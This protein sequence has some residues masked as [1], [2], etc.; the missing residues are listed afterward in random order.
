MIDAV[1]SP[2]VLRDPVHN[3]IPLDG[4]DGA[5]VL[6]LIDTP[7]FQRLRRIRQL[8]LAH[9]T[10]PGAEHTRWSH[11]VG[12][13]RIAHRMLDTLFRQ[14]PSRSAERRELAPL[15]KEILAAAL[16]HDIGHGPFSHVFER[17]I[18][19]P[20]NAPKEY[21]RKHENW[22][23]RIIQDQL[24]PV[25]ANLG[26]ETDVVAGLIDKKSRQNLLAKDFISSQL[27]ADRLDY[28]LRDSWATG[29]GYGKFDLD[30]M[31]HSLRIG[32]TKVKGQTR[33][34]H[35]LCLDG[36]KATSV[37]EAYIQARA[38]MHREVYVHKTTRAY[39]ALL[40]NILGLASRICGGDPGRAPAPCPPAL[41]K[42]LAGKTVTVREYLSLDDFSLWTMLGMWR[43]LVPNGDNETENL[44]RMCRKLVNREQPYRFVDLV[45]EQELMTPAIELMSDLRDT[46]SEFACSRDT[47]GDIAYKNAL[48][49][50]SDNRDEEED[51]RVVYFLVNGTPCPA[52]G[53]SPVIDALARI[54]AKID[55]LYY[56]T[57]D[58]ELMARLRNKGLIK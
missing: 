27:D 16:L 37:F 5:L 44:A 21:P 23:I 13:W 22:S 55:R 48:Y 17:A 40:I 24:A 4:E 56:D 52:E 50:R 25:L 51:N 34:V 32:K 1:D 6:V 20:E 46:P 45:K 47:F 28:L 12:V 26:I 58:G 10:Y 2:K 11:S 35:R 7:E 31:I 53:E 33:S 39:E 15:R 38:Y 14:Y 3:L 42:M 18:S 43:H 41:A 54:E 29:T 49:R 9:L 19:R 36:L 8:G 30:W 57:D